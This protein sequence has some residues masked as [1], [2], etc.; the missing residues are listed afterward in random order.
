[1]R[2]TIN[3]AMSLAAAAFSAM[4]ESAEKAA[5]SIQVSKP[6]MTPNPACQ[7]LQHM[8]VAN[9][10]L[11]GG[12]KMR[13]ESHTKSGTG[14]RHV[15]GDGTHEHLTLKQRNAGAY[16]KGLR[17]WINGSFTRASAV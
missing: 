14:R 17:N 12:G 10:G 5:Q 2:Q 3:K 16:G 6:Q 13:S 8:G 4:G 9:I 1:M 11:P 7:L 15:Q